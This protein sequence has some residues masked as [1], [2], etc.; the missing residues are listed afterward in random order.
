MS[1]AYVVKQGDCLSSIAKQF[2][3]ADWRR[4]YDDPQNAA[5]RKLRP[6]PNL[7]FPGDRLVVPDREP[8]EVGR[9]TNAR[10]TF[11]TK[12]AQKTRVRLKLKDADDEAFAGR[13]YRLVIDGATFDGST[14]GAGMIE[15]DIAADASDGTLTL[16]L[17]NDTSKPGI[18][19]SLKVGHLD[20]VEEASGVQARL[21]NLGY[22]C[23]KI[24]GVVGPLTQ[25]AIAAFQLRQGLA[26]TG[27]VDAATRSRLRQLHDEE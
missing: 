9:A 5:F 27:V 19:W 20:P 18:V 1:T 17:D 7:I 23:G 26:V 14:D 13:K 12:G 4:I 15:H 25:A 3:F 24:D 16:F 2:G 8:K 22:A 10:H 6:N 11:R 21:R